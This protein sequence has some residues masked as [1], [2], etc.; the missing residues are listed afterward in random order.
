MKCDNKIKFEIVYGVPN[1]ARIVRL[2]LATKVHLIYSILPF[3]L[4]VYPS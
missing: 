3:P 4:I 2:R 1:N